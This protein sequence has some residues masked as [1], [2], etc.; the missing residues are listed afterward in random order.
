MQASVAR[1][2]AEAPQDFAMLGITR[3]EDVLASLILDDAG[4][5]ELGAGAAINRDG[6]N[7]LQNWSHRL[8]SRALS[9]GADRLCAPVDPLVRALPAG[10]D[11]FALLR[12]L[13]PARAERV[14]AS[15]PD[16][17][18]REVGLA[19]AEIAERKRSGPRRRLEDVLAQQPRHTEARAALLRLSATAIADGAD[20]EA[21]VAPP[22]SD[23]ER[24]VAAGWVGR[25]R[26]RSG[27]AL[28]E[29]EAA[30]AAVPANHP[31][32]VEATRLRIQARLPSGDPELTREAVALAEASLGDRPRVQDL[33]LRAEAYAIAN[34]HSGTLETIGVILDRVDPRTPSNRG[35]IRR[36]RDLVR[37]VPD[38]PEFGPLR[39]QIARRL[40]I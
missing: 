26:D 33:L 25:E 9:R 13:P 16:A 36:A 38:D 12:R 24:A 23:A 7:R 34:E 18:D 19:I 22:L 4:V 32:A 20:P 40:G 10:T 14:A 35:I 3:P 27:A 28:R 29:L 8:G 37:A 6:H 2:L 39:T 17:I 5:R 21:T 30:L 11:V 31:L 15:L 1:A